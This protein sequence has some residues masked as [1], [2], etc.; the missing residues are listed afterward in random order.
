MISNIICLPTGLSLA[1]D[2]SE[3]LQRYGNVLSTVAELGH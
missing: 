1:N 2:T 3:R